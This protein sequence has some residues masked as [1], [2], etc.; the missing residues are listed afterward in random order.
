MSRLF[1]ITHA[2]V[3]IDPGI[4]VP[5]WGLSQ[6]GAARHAAF[7]QR[8]VR[9]CAIWSSSEHKAREGAGFLADV[10]N[11][12]VSVDPDLG[13]NDRSTTGFLPPDV[14]EQAADAFFAKPDTSYRGW[15]T[16]SDAQSRVVSALKRIETASPKGDIA[17]IAH[18]A[19]GALTRA[20]A[21]SAPIS[22]VHDQTGSCGNVMVLARPT[23]EFLS[24][25]T[26]MEELLTE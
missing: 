20:W 7:A 17:V 22:R 11:L 14:F 12:A 21:M 4:P 18:G 24:G 9:F 10:Q 23:F 19:V 25:W 16:A 6:L 1:F 13:E 26:P 3:D 15:E 8:A 5:E 2:E